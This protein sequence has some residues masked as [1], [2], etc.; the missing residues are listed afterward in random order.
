MD[1]RLLD[2]AAD[3]PRAGRHHGLGQRQVGRRDGRCPVVVRWLAADRLVRDG[4]GQCRARGGDHQRIAGPQRQVLEGRQEG[5]LAPLD[6]AHRHVLERRE[7]AGDGLRAGQRMAVADIDL[8]DELLAGAAGD[9][10]GHAGARLEQ[11]RQ[12][13]GDIEEAGERHCPRRNGEIEEADPEA[14]DLLG[15]AGGQQ[16]G[17]SADERRHA[18]EQRREGERQQRLGGGH[19]A[20]GRDRG[21]DRQEHDHHRRVVD[22]GAGDHR[23]GQHQIDGAHAGAPA[24]PS[25]KRGRFLQRIGV[26][27][28]LADDQQGKNG[29]ERRV[30]EAGEQRVGSERALD[31]GDLRH[32]PEQH[33]PADQRHHRDDLDRPALERIGDD[34]RHDRRIGKPGQDCRCRRCHLVPLGKH[35]ARAPETLK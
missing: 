12:D 31:A 24:E 22:D 27:Q 13:E 28:A 30:G 18:A 26:E 3:D 15:D 9:L 23:R 20:A 6:E 19:A 21:D 29:D 2:G 32:R 4:A 34:H 17:R 25:Q 14:P 35:H 10:L 16:V 1:R 8:G 5:M 7:H 33:Q 11:L